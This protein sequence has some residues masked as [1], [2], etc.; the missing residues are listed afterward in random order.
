MLFTKRVQALVSLGKPGYQVK[1]VKLS[2][3]IEPLMYC[4]MVDPKEKHGY[5]TYPKCF[6]RIPGSQGTYTE[7]VQLCFDSLV[8]SFL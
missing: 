1:T 4:Q 6:S 2:V 8:I 3:F 7:N 5:A